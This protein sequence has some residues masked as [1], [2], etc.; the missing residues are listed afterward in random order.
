MR[1]ILFLLGLLL[2]VGSWAQDKK[3][4]VFFDKNGRRTSYKKL[5]RK[6]EKADIVLF[7]DY[8]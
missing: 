6:S 4:Y 7:G 1:M 3:A 5:L 8:R 2:T